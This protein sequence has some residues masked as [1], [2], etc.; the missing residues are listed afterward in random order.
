MR[1]GLL[2]GDPAL[3]RALAIAASA[4]ARATADTGHETAHRADGDVHPLKRDVTTEHRAVTNPGAPLCPN[5]RRIHVHRRSTSDCRPGPP[6]RMDGRGH[7][8]AAARSKAATSGRRR[9]LTAIGVSEQ[10]CGLPRPAAILCLLASPWWRRRIRML[11][12]TTTTRPSDHRFLWRTDFGGTPQRWAK[13][14]ASGDAHGVSFSP[15]WS[16]PCW[17]GSACRAAGCPTPLSRS[18]RIAFQAG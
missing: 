11:D 1:R 13:D 16:D 12:R 14:P 3:S 7:H 18:G 8:L 15:S 2:S 6:R 10:A 9:Q 5:A 17:R 4:L